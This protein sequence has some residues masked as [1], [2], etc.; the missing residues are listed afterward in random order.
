MSQVLSPSKLAIQVSTLCCNGV[1]GTCDP[2]GLACRGQ[3][4]PIC[5]AD[6]DPAYQMS[7]ATRLLLA[8]HSA[9]MCT[10]DQAFR[11]A[12]ID[13]L[14]AAP[15]K[16]QIDKCQGIQYHECAIDDLGWSVGHAICY[17][18]RMQVVHCIYSDDQIA[19]R[20]A[21]IRFGAGA[22]CDPAVEAW[23]GCSKG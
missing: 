4:S 11:G 7:E 13:G 1:I 18:D 12:A 17:S 20:R 6:S 21:E 3:R 10:F 22:P 14:F 19:L 8:K 5:V 16:E 23:L 9:S 15:A 2:E